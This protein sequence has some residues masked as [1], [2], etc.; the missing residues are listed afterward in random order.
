MLIWSPFARRAVWTFAAVLLG[1][2]FLA[3]L[4]VILAASFAQQW[5]DI[6]PS[7][8]TL[9]HYA[10]MI[11]GAAGDAVWASLVTGLIASFVAL[12]SGTWAALA[13]RLYSAPLQQ[14]IGLLFFIPS[15]VPSVSV[16][17]GLLVAF[18]QKPL[19]LNGTTAIVLIAHFVLISAFTFG[20]VSAGLSR[21]SPDYEQVASA[22][23][24]RPAYC[25][26]HVTLPLIAPYLVAAFGLS[27]A[28]SM[29]ELGATVMVYP[30]GWV[31]LPVAIFGLTDRGDI[32]SGAALTMFLILTTLALLVGLGRLP[33]KVA[34]QR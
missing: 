22:L 1:L 28:L 2:L 9:E 26:W 23:G 24:A 6:L 13:L 25:L 21:L 3:P 8:F 32:F 12:V 30:P 14:L 16:G 7:G 15:A 33:L 10:G 18:S 11:S 5:N 17:L 27:V 34:A 20:N 19:L 4:A 31:T 29:G